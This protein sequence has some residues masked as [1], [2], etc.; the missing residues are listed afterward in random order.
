MSTRRTG[1]PAGPGGARH[2]GIVKRVVLD[3][4]VLVSFLTDRDAEQQEQAAALFETAAQGEAELI[5]HQ[6][7]GES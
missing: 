5:L 4:N 3:T 6:E 2:R 1:A 7:D